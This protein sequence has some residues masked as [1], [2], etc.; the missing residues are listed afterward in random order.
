[1]IMRRV[2]RE[3]V[4]HFMFL[5]LAIFSAGQ[6]WPKESDERRI[7]IDRKRIEGIR[8]NYVSE[9]GTQPSKTQMKFLVDANVRDEIFYREGLALQLDRGDEIVRR[10]VI[11]KAEFLL[12]DVSPSPQP[13]PAD[14][15]AYY[16]DHIPDYVIP[17]RTSF[18]HIYFSVETGDGRARALAALK[19][20]RMK[21]LD[22]APELGDTFSDQYDYSA[23]GKTAVQRVFGTSKFSAATFEVSIGEWAG[24]FRSGLGWHLLRVTARVKPRKAPFEEIKDI[25][26]TDW[27]KAAGAKANAKAFLRLNAKYT[28]V[29]E[30]SKYG[31]RSNRAAVASVSEKNP[32]KG[33][34][35]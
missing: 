2:F 15:R 13:T 21:S 12:Q 11:Q 22:R 10:R 14:I 18:T 35:N 19:K 33:D 32:D 5:G 31:M 3:P 30:D 24:P 34:Q 28:V 16:Q 8:Q 25:V 17:A 7:V 26:R 4:V 6:L 27:Q 1:M 20:L 9:Y 29:R 23:M